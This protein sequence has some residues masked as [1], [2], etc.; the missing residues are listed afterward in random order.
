MVD[1]KIK[2][3]PSFRELDKQIKGMESLSSLT[4]VLSIF[5]LVKGDVSQQFSQLAEMK[6]QFNLLSNLPDRFNKHF[7][8]LGWIAYEIINVDLMKQAVDLAEKGKIDEAE[9]VLIDYYNEENLRFLIGRLRGIEEF[10]PRYTLIQ[11]AFEDYIAG[12]YHACIPVVL[13][14]I[15]GVV[16]DIEQKGFFAQGS[17]FSVWDSIAG[18]SSGLNQLVKLLTKTRRKTTTEEIFIPYRNG[19]LHGRDLSYDNKAVAAKCWAALLA[20]RDW[21]GAIK[22]GKKNPPPPHKE[23]GLLENLKSIGDTLDSLKEL[24]V[25]KQKIREWKPREIVIGNNC[26]ETGHSS[27][28]EEGSPERDAVCFLEYWR[29]RNYGKMAQQVKQFV[30]N[31]SINK[32]AGR[33]REIFEG[34][35]LVN[36]KIDST[37]QTKK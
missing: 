21:A 11:K 4:Q 27:D 19:I 10:R 8:D 16:N 31:T 7:A 25:T 18:H 23:P 17:D 35:N 29:N 34:K 20:I 13:M 26:P 1:D 32:M 6:E 36:F 9:S 12:R 30:N 14:M 2:D 22:E 33:I 5:G 3:N 24:E 37:A 15:D 28:Y